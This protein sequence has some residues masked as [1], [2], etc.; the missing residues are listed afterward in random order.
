MFDTKTQQT[1]DLSNEITK[2]AYHWCKMNSAPELM[3]VIAMTVLAGKMHQQLPKSLQNDVLQL[4]EVIMAL[5]E[6]VPEN[7][8]KQFLDSQ[9]A[10][11]ED[12]INAK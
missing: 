7:E 9:G 3:A 6:G 1:L 12:I 11:L 8:A 5:T 10:S 2:F 4:A